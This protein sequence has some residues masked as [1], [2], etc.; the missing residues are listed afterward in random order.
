MME[1]TTDKSLYIYIHIYRRELSQRDKPLAFWSLCLVMPAML[2]YVLGFRAARNVC[3][4]EQEEYNHHRW[5][6]SK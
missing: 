6:K 3:V 1:R 4:F 2:N 5:M